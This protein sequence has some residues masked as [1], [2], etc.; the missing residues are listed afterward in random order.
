[1]AT[2]SHRWHQ[3]EELYHA[4]LEC[5][6]GDRAALLAR[7]EP[8]L[9]REVESLLA[10]PTADLALSQSAWEQAL[11]ALPVPG[12]QVVAG[13]HLGPFKIESTLGAGGMGQVYRAVDT[14]LNRPVAIKIARE[15]FGERFGREARAIAQLNHPH[16]CTLYDVGPNYLVMELVDG[17]TLDTRLTN[18][19]LPVDVV[20]RYGV[21]LADAL[22]AAHARGIVHRDLKPGNIM[23]TKAGV[24]VLD[25]G[26][27]K[28][29][30][31]DSLTQSHAVMGTPAYMA[32]EQR[33]GKL[34]DARTD[35][36]ALGLVLREMA[37]GK[38]AEDMQ[39]LPPQFIHVV[40][41]CLESDPAERW[42]AASD[43][44]KELEWAAVTPAAPAVTGDTS[45]RLA[46]GVAALAVA[47]MLAVGVVYLQRESVRTLGPTQFTVSFEKEIGGVGAFPDPSPTGE[48]FVFT[49]IGPKGGTSL[50]IRSLDSAEARSLAG[51]EGA[52]GPI[53]SPDGNWIAFYADGKLKKVNPQGGPPQTI[54]AL[55][56][57]QDA[58]WGP[59][60]DIIY[61]PTNRAPL[62]RIRDSGGSPQP[63]TTLNAS[64]TENSHRFPEFLPDGRRF[65]FTSRCGERANNALYLGSLDSPDVTRVMPAQS[66]VSYIPPVRGRPE[67]LIY[68]R[69]GALVAQPFD[70]DERTLTDE[71][72]A[73]VDRVGYNATGLEARFRVSRDGRIIVFS[74]AEPTSTRLIW[75][76]R[77]GEEE[78]TL[79]TPAE[80]IQP[81]ISP[82][83]D[84]VAFS[85]PDQQTG[86][87]EVWY[88]EIAR[89]ITARL[90]THVANDWYP[91][92]S[93]DGRQVLFGS[94]RD[95]GAGHVPYLKTSM[96]PGSSE[97]RPQG[98]SER[99]AVPDLL[100]SDWSADGRWIAYVGYA[101]AS[102]RGDLY[103]GPAFGSSEPFRFLATAA[104]ETH[105]RFSPDSRWIVYN[106]DESG[107]MEV[108]ARLFSGEPAPP[109]GK[110]QVSNNGG[111]Y[112]V[113]EPSGREIF[114]MSGD[115]SVFAVDTRNLGRTETLPAPVRLFQA[116]P[117][118][119]PL[120]MPLRG[121]YDHSFDT[122]DG[123][124]F[125]V[126]CLAEPPGRFTVLMNWTF[127]K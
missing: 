52:T 107:R 47:G 75:F 68:Y 88:L 106:S 1:M 39:D 55:P 14:R 51:T 3:V 67:S 117:A 36:Y 80:R 73:L 23:L 115:G 58:A 105:P 64:L 34:A 98:L 91:V 72:A 89:G 48:A 37:T 49:G 84:R 6:A 32:P 10:Q 102:L 4:A 97:F 25:F 43:V 109:T 83:G 81:R 5:E 21:Q 12:T 120:A 54:A 121:R 42:Q 11:A 46:W 82:R 104:W 56:G 7:A 44:K 61:R 45:S 53:W 40:Q 26:L 9:R 114:Y 96:D 123:Q 33:Q 60:G 118:T 111:E 85:A 94:D 41:R 20:L 31:D 29:Q 71:P 90:T 70:L 112:G 99:V 126:N 66:A 18:G 108:Y 87:R 50:W 113:W 30:T 19:A 63:L 125:L 15:Q 86:N 101:Q 17:D 93:P 2:G 78:G 57:F 116:C 79:G 122:R 95:G 124:R 65:L 28:T 8:D 35:I 76:N 103:V 59:H 74:A 16:I 100:P 22:A 27:A 110:L 62:F 77:H 119:Q 127:P 92:W 38:Q 24:K 13:T 69:D